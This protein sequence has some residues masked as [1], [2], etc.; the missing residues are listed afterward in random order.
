ML[1]DVD[2]VPV[3][4]SQ[5]L[6]VFVFLLPGLVVQ[7]LLPGLDLLLPVL[8]HLGQLQCLLPVRA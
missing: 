3:L 1:I 7:C 6:L 8:E 2:I 5:V 4:A